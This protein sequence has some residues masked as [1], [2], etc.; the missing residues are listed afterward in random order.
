MNVAKQIVTAT[1]MTKIEYE[2]FLGKLF[3]IEPLEFEKGISTQHGETDAV[4]ANV[5]VL[6]GKNNTEEFA[7]A[8]I[9]PR[10]LVG[11]L[12]SKIGSIVVGRLTQGVKQKGKNAPWL[13]VAGEQEEADLKR[14]ADFLA[15]RS[16]SSASG[17][18]D[19]YDEDG[20]DDEDAF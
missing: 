9:F 19:D 8:L 15:A 17:S 12:R 5:W 3:V 1:P 18:D 16:V 11:S 14:A 13:L 7:D 20:G 6:L 2:E 4:R 10:A